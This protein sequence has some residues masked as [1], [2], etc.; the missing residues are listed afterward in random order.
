MVDFM[1]L[2]QPD[3]DPE[4]WTKAVAGDAQAA[5]HPVGGHRGLRRPHRRLD[6]RRPSTPPP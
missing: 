6:P 4:A 1:F 2:D 3:I 5:D